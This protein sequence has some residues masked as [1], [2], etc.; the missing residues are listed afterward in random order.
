MPHRGVFQRGE[1]WRWRNLPQDPSISLPTEHKLR[2]PLVGSTH[3]AREEEFER[4]SSSSGADRCIRC[5]TGHSGPMGWDE[6]QH[7]TQDDSNAL[8]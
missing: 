5:V 7:V 3:T 4:T 2:E 8:R 1:A 6:D